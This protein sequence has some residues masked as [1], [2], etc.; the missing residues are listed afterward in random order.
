MYPSGLRSLSKVECTIGS[1]G[2]VGEI[3]LGVCEPDLVSK[4]MSP[5]SDSLASERF[6]CLAPGRL[7][8]CLNF[9]SHAVLFT[10]AWHSWLPTVVAK[11]RALSRI[12]S[13]FRGKP[14]LTWFRAQLAMARSISGNLPLPLFTGERLPSSGNKYL[15]FCRRTLETVLR[16]VS[17]GFHVPVY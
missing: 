9:S 4:C 1:S 15:S 2:E 11:K 16:C 5:P 10:L 8:F 3:A 17:T 13:S 7:F 14:C 6:L 12:M